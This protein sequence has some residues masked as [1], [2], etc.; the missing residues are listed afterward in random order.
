MPA[1]P[2]K[3]HEGKSNPSVGNNLAAPASSTGSTARGLS[4]VNVKCPAT[5]ARIPKVFNGCDSRPLCFIGVVEPVIDAAIPQLPASGRRASIA[6]EKP[7]HHSPE[8]LYMAPVLTA[9]DGRKSLTGPAA[10]HADRVPKMR[11]LIQYASSVEAMPR[12]A[13][14]TTSDA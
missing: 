4:D 11:R 5:P 8:K 12:A 1:R 7:V 3:P 2:E 14:A 6:V 10:F 9:S 13:P